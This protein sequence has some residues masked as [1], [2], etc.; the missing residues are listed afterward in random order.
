MAEQFL[1]DALSALLSS[2][3]IPQLNAPVAQVAV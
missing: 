1:L 3:S 2:A